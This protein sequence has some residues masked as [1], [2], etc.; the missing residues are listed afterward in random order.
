MGSG[1]SRSMVGC[2]MPLPVQQNTKQ[3]S[4]A[5]FSDPSYDEGLGHS[6]CYIRPLAD[7][8]LHIAHSKIDGE[9]GHVSEESLAVGQSHGDHTDCWK[10]HPETTFKAI[11][12]ASVSANTSTPCT[13]VWH[14]QIQTFTTVPDDRAAAFECTSSFTS[15]PLQPVPKGSNSNPSIFSGPISLPLDQALLSGSLDR[16]IPSG[17]LERGFLSGPLE[18]SSGPM[19]LSLDPSH[20]S[21]PLPGSY[22]NYIGHKRRV[23]GL[24]DVV[25][26]PVQRVWSGASSRMKSV[27]LHTHKMGANS[28]N[29]L[30]YKGSVPLQANE[31]RNLQWAH[32]KAGEDRM[33]VVLSDKHGWLFV[34]IYDGF[35]GPDAPDFLMRNLYA[36]V[37]KELKGL[38]C[39]IEGDFSSEAARAKPAEDHVPQHLPKDQVKGCAAAN[40]FYESEGGQQKVEKI[41]SLKKTPRSKRGIKPQRGLSFPSSHYLRDKEN[42]MPF[43]DSYRSLHGELDSHAAKTFK[44]NG[45]DHSAVLEALACALEA[46]E[47]AYLDMADR[48]L[49]ENPELALMGSCILVMLMQDEDVYIMN[50]GDSRAILGQR[51]MHVGGHHKRRFSQ[52]DLQYHN[53]GDS[54]EKIGARDSLMRM[55]LERI[56]EESPL[57]E[58]EAFE[59]PCLNSMS[60]TTNLLLR[61]LQLSKDHC[62]SVEEE[63]KRIKAEHSDSDLLINDRVKGTLKVTRAF[64]AGF[65]KKPQWNSAILEM[66]RINYVGS[67]PYIS[68]S[69]SLRHH[70][71]TQNDRFLILSS[72]GL[73]QYL[74]NQEAVSHVEWFMEMFPE[75]D[76]AQHLVEELLFRAAKK[77]G[78]DFHQLLGVPQGDRRKYHDDVSVMVISLQGRIWRSCS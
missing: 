78:M 16:G 32:G 26:R 22:V 24:I 61:A 15:L 74:S 65:L 8:P 62:T 42:Y 35:N 36:S 25:R 38:L 5:L 41:F 56:I 66:F 21:A 33:H 27:D 40:G 14:E 72:D 34:G 47:K 30:T 53:N 39:D 68:C 45:A 2:F 58:Q 31:I 9:N 63:V 46:T 44:R 19:D 73:N 6:F 52:E 50:V 71:L 69:P 20:F 77:A 4:N 11:S 51:Q 48:A 1:L 55:D 43:A 57:T 49:N 75:G 64:G 59:V 3:H 7:S 54:K 70:R 29:D 76:P 28:F 10:A 13:I 37:Y 18:R 17:L 60:S 12:G 67:A 23:A